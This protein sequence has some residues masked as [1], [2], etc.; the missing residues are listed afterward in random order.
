MGQGLKG[1]ATVNTKQSK[2]RE[3]SY[4]IRQ[5]GQC[6]TSFQAEHLK[7]GEVLNRFRQLV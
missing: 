2:C 7:G 3:L 1:R 4:P 6:T 5:H